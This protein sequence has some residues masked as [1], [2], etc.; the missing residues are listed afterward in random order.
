MPQAPALLRH[1]HRLA[2]PRGESRSD[3]ELL[4]RFVALHEQTAFNELLRRH[5]PLVWGVCRRVLGREH[6]AEDAFQA[7]FLVLV[8]RARFIRKGESLSSFLYGVAYRVA[9]RLR[10]QAAQRRDCERRANTMPATDVLTQAA[11][12]EFQALLDEELNGLPEKYRAPVVLC[13]LEGKSREQA[14]RELGWK[15]GTLSSRLAQARGRLQRRLARRGV[16]LAALLCGADLGRAADAAVPAALVEATSQMALAAVAGLAVVPTAAAAA[17]GVLRSLSLGPWKILGTLLLAV[18]VACG[19]A[20]KPEEPPQQGPPSAPLAQRRARATGVDRYGDSLPEGAIAR[21]GSLRRHHGF[22]I[23]AVA[24]SPDGKV[25]ASAGG[26]RGLCLWDMATGK[27]LH[28]VVPTRHVYGVAFSPDGK[29]LAG[30]Y[31]TQAVYLWDV[32]SGKEMRR[33]GGN[34]GGVTM[35]FAFSPDG[36]TLASGGHDMLVRLWNLATGAE[37]RQLRGATGTIRSVAYSPDG[38]LVAAGGVGKD[39]PLWDAA[40]GEAR[41]TLSG[42]KA[43]ALW[44]AFSPDGRTLASGDDQTVRLWD[45][46]GRKERAVLAGGSTVG[47]VAFSPDGK[48][49]ASAHADGK[50]RLWDADSGKEVRSIQAHALRADALAFTPDGKTLVSGAMWDSTVRL[51]DPTTGRERRPL[52]GPH[53]IAHWLQF[54]PDGHSLFVAARDQKLRR[55]D[56][57]RDQESTVVSWHAPSV[58]NAETLTAAG[59]VVASYDYKSQTISVWDRAAD[60]P[61]WRCKHPGADFAL[62]LSPDGRLL[63]SGG[64]DRTLRLWDLADGKEIRKVE[65]LEDEAG[66]LAFSPD[67]K[68]LASGSSNRGNPVPLRGRSLRLYDTATLKE[69]RAFDC[70][71]EHVYGSVFSPDGAWLVTV[72]G[73]YPYRVR[74]WDIATGKE[75]FLPPT[76]KRCYGLAFSPDSKL[77]LVGTEEPENAAV[78]VEIASGQEIRRFA[79]HKS[80]V[81][82]AAFSPDGKLLAT[83]GG[84]A[85]VLLWDLAGKRTGAAPAGEKCWAALA[86]TDAAKAHATLRELAADPRQAVPLLRERLRP[87]PPLDEARRRQ[88]KRWLADL[89]NDSFAVRQQAARGLEE[90]GDLAA[91][92]LREAL[93]GK[94]AAEARRQIEGILEGVRGW[95][96]SR[97]R[98]TRAVTALEQ[99]DTPRARRLL[100]ELA[101]GAPEAL[102]T[103]EARAALDRLG[104]RPAV[105]P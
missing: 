77:L 44:V 51:W 26:G 70:T 92:A 97:L 64:R 91:P 11:C 24:V 32:A 78:V 86:D 82:A 23:Y 67:G 59:P 73:P 30:S 58:F 15:E 25:L 43:D 99:A 7:A 75:H 63:A 42:H 20:G 1:I 27:L 72:G 80:G 16:A 49:V 66:F 14:A 81:A 9:V 39:V 5:G 101:A 31:S 37:L 96:T 71:E 13:C 76:L 33:L 29:L 12:R 62:A 46:P 84:D 60:E 56:W 65:G 4:Q 85:N 48:L 19:V 2:A 47:A 61:R 104:K 93:A 90:V 34:A 94:P 3:G 28:E 35:A 69:L 40:T 22:L 45:V 53:G 38:R 87:V 98:V 21:L 17:A 8:R 68:T 36:K 54:A 102:L 100:E 83:G 89:D 105:T 52:A 55:W 103:R 18:G 57:A 41:G 6:E 10:H 74:L 88:V 79:G 95:S 50:V